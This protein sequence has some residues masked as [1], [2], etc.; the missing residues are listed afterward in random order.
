MDRKILAERI[1]ALGIELRKVAMDTRAFAAD[2][3]VGFD[4]RDTVSDMLET[5]DDLMY[6]GMDVRTYQTR[7]M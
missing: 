3:A 1:E 4:F 2:N 7:R 6:I 5:A